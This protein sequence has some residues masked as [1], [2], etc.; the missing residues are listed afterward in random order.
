MFLYGVFLIYLEKSV[1]CFKGFFFDLRH[2]TNLIYIVNCLS[3]M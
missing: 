2:V 3:E 1:L